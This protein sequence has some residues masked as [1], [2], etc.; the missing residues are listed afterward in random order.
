[1]R[2]IINTR[3]AKTKPNTIKSIF[4]IWFWIFTTIYCII[5]VF[6][7]LWC[8]IWVGG[9]GSAHVCHFPVWVSTESQNEQ[10]KRWLYR[11][12]F[13]MCLQVGSPP[14]LERE[15]EWRGIQLFAINEMPL[16]PTHLTFKAK[17]TVRLWVKA[18]SCYVFWYLVNTTYQWLWSN[19]LIKRHTIKQLSWGRLV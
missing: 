9:N 7:P 3:Q 5:L 6:F 12:A 14:C 16:N 13:H 18:L 4:C 8:R 2:F 15:G 1:M 10:T 17:V 11:G 19:M